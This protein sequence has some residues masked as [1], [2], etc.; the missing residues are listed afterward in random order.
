MRECHSPSEADIAMAR[1]S[2][3]EIVNSTLGECH[4]PAVADVV[5]AWRRGRGVA[6]AISQYIAAQY[7][8]SPIHSPTANE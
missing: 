4:S 8:Q 7:E 3:L 1:M 5:Q 2:L 6:F